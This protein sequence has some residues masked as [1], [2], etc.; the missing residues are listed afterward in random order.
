MVFHSGNTAYSTAGIY[1]NASTDSIYAT[2]YYETSDANYKTNIKVINDSNNIPE[3]REFDWKEDGSHSYGFIAQELEA[4]GY[5]ELVSTDE[6]GKKT[7]NYSATLSL[8]VGKMQKK[9]EELE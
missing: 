9:I 4:R 1:C 8:V 5:D 2:H 7:V 6:V 3:V